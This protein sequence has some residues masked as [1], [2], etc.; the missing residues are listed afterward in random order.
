MDTAPT[1]VVIERTDASATIEPDATPEEPKGAHAIEFGFGG[2]LR[3]GIAESGVVGVTAFLEEGLGKSV[4]LRLAAL[5]GQAPANGLRMTWA[6][7][8][9]A[10]CMG[11]D[12]NYA[13]GSGLRLDL[14]G[15]LDAGAT[16]VASGTG[17]SP[18][19][20]GQSLPY[21]AFGPSVGLRAE[22]GTGAAL[23]FRFGLG[24]NVARD[25][26]TDSTGTLVEPPLASLHLELDISFDLPRGRSASR[27]A[28]TSGTLA[29]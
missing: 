11:S 29:R 20:V 26:F 7:G 17:G 25:Q 16:F 21:I 1:A 27:V 15:G 2:F 14:C 28:S 18:P 6:A 10:T 3:S 12:G 9:V 19:N 22:L 8:S 5:A 23:T 24:L 13:R 4:F